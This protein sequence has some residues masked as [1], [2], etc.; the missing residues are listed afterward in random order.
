MRPVNK[1]GVVVTIYFIR[2][3]PQV[4]DVLNTCTWE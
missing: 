3:A 4:H 1:F 2:L